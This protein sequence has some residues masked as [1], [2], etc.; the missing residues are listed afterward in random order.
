MLFTSDCVLN[1]VDAIMSVEIC[2]S[3]ALAVGLYVW[4]SQVG[5][6]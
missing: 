5:L 6:H 3:S 1:C 2:L 4:H